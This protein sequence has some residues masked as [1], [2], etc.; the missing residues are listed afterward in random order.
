MSDPAAAPTL[1]PENIGLVGI[2]LVGSA[3]AQ[4]LLESGYGVVGHDLDPERRRQLESW[5]GTPASSPA[6]VAGRTGRVLLSLPD[7]AAVQEVVE[8]RDGLLQGRPLPAAVI[9]TTTGDP[10]ATCR[11]AARLA[12]RQV[13]YLDATLSGSSAQI[14]QHACTLMVGGSPAQVQAHTDLLQVLSP[15]RHHLGPAGSG[16]R[17]KLAVNLVVGLNRAALAEGLVLA[18]AQGLDL[19]AFLALLKDSPAYS[20]AMDTKGERMLQGDFAPDARL[21]QH[22]KDVELILAGGRQA[23]QPLPL[24][25]CHRQLLADAVAAGDGDLDNAAV[26][27]QWRRL[28]GSPDD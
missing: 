19:P 23:G 24:S 22:L 15:R 8:G 9:D 1:T 28:K 6:E 18:E 21:R 10:E 5:G 26:I 27:R 25:A 4:R 20:A 17:A 16:A 7:S 13:A 11:L 14:R 2:G 12:A 3:L